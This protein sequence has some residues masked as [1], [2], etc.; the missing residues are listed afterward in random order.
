MELWWESLTILEKIA[1]Y[2]AAPATLIL[3]IQTLLQLFG[4]V[5]GVGGDADL[6]D[7]GEPHF[8]LHDGEH[9]GHDG[10]E[11]TDSGPSF[12]TVRGYVT[13]F[14]IFGWCFLA[15]SRSGTASGMALV[16]AFVLGAAAMVL[17]GFVLYWSLKLQSDGTVHLANAV[18]QTGR[19]YLTVPA[20]RGGLGKVNVLIQERYTECD[21]VT[22]EEERIET[23]AEVVITGVTGRN[24][25]IV[26]RKRPA[27]HT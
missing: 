1:V 21:A 19:V 15:L 16:I 11:H 22:D 8:D 2:I 6:H 9:A 24:M 5:G 7:G 12:F 23:G 18:G 25:L 17:T 4:A 10:A 20:A 26:R 14:T 27:N 3:F 13:F